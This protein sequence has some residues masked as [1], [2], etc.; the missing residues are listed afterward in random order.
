VVLA[1]K[2]NLFP[3]IVRE[4]KQCKGPDNQLV[5]SVMSGITIADIE[6]VFN[7]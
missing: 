1:V 5:L 7:I 4:L 6:K 3:V 2:P